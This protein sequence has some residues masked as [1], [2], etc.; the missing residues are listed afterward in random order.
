[1]RL[2]LVLPVHAWPG[3][4]PA[5]QPQQQ[6]VSE[7]V[8]AHNKIVSVLIA[9][10]C[11]FMLIVCWPVVDRERERE[12]RCVWRCAFPAQQTH[13]L[14]HCQSLPLCACCVTYPPPPVYVCVGPSEDGGGGNRFE[15]ALYG[16]LCGD[17]RSMLPAC[18]SWED[19]AWAYCRWV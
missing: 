19:E 7:R 2:R 10:S 13:C 15:A 6:Q 8:C 1:M 11:L 4:G 17:V 16:A 18:D 9:Q 14:S 5:V 3:G 12:H